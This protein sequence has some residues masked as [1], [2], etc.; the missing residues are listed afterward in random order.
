MV[1]SG[2]A[3]AAAAALVGLPPIPERDETQ[4]LIQCMQWIGFND[5]DARTEIVN[6]SFQFY[7]DLY[8]LC[9]KEIDTLSTSFSS[10]TVANGRINFGLRR[11]KKIKFLLHWVQDFRRVSIKPMMVDK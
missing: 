1:A 11:T 3:A 9:E 5:A 7:E 8:D 6:E 4:E 10:R 2:Q